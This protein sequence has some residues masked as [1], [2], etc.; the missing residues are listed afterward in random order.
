MKSPW[1]VGTNAVDVEREAVKE[2]PVV[3]RLVKENQKR[4]EFTRVRAGTPKATPRY[5]WVYF[6][7]TPKAR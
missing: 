3:M 4:S 7:G 2:R 5:P 6:V 1:C